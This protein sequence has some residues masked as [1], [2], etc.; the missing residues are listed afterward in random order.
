MTYDQ[1]FYGA[2]E[3]LGNAFSAPLDREPLKTVSA[4]APLRA[5]PN[6]NCVHG[7]LLLDRTVE[8]CIE[9]GHV[10]QIRERFTSCIDRV[11]SRRIVQRGERDKREDL[12]SNDLV[13]DHRIQEAR[14]SVD[15]AMSN[16]IQRSWSVRER[17]DRDAAPVIFD[18]VKLQARRACIDHEDCA[19]R[20]AQ[21][22]QVQS[23]ISAGS[24]P[25]A[26]PYARAR[27]RAS[28][29]SWRR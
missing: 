9:D 21:P 26:R 10:R 29:I 23:R 18:R 17:V 2:A 15:H 3:E 27:R 1:A 16:G 14:S 20:A 11:E 8:G 28:T 13:D 5:P 19:H 12:V 25:C 4:Y 24:S 6:R 22:G 7:G